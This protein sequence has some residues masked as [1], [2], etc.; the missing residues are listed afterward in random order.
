MQEADGQLHPVLYISRK[1]SPA[2]KNYAIIEK[3]CLAIVWAVTKLSKYLLGAPFTL[4]T[5]H[6]PL[7]ALDRKKLSNAK[8]TRWSLILQDFIFNIVY[9]PG[10]QNK[11]ADTLSRS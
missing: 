2:E 6:S 9:I 7:V 11:I 8:L 5:D 4:M 1:L 10:V 3:E